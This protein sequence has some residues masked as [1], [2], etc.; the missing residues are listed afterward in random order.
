MATWVLAFFTDN[1]GPVT[2]LS[3]TLR[4]RDVSDGS[5]VVTD[6]AT[7]EKGDGHYAYDFTS[8]YDYSK[9]YAIR[10]DGGVTLANN[11]RYKHAGNESFVDDIDSVL[12]ANTTLIAVSAAV[13]EN[14]DYLQRIIGLVHENIYIDQPVYDGD[15]NLTSARLRIYS[16]PSDVGTS[17][18]VIGTY[19]I[20]APGDGAGRFVSWKQVRS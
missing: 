4:I 14:Q 8:L 6:A 9:D 11:F 10:V 13:I 12:D 20:T 3:P 7:V 17:N 1:D 18:G 19:Q 15:S 16:N 2:G 5:L